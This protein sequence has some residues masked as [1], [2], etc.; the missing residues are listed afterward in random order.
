MNRQTVRHTDIQAYSQTHIWMDIRTSDSYN[1]RRQLDRGT[2][3]QKDTQEARE[4]DIQ[5]E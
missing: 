4:A 2:E 1:H 5:T 3:R